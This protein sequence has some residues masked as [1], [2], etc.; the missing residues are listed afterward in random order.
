MLLDDV[1]DDVGRRVVD[2]AR[3]AD[4]GLLL[5]LRLVPVGQPDHLA[6]E[7]LVDLA[8]DLGGQHGE[9]VGAVGVVELADDLLERLVVD[10]QAEGQLVG[11]LRRGPSPA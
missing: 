3:L 6:Q 11:R 2:A 1:I 5:D 9:L 8:E 10:G 7:L 4:L